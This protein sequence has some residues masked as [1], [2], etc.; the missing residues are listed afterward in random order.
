MSS[1]ARRIPE[2]ELHAYADGLLLV[3]RAFEEPSYPY[4]EALPDPAREAAHLTGELAFADLEVATRRL[5]KLDTTGRRAGL[6]DDPAKPY[7]AA[8]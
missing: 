4:A 2:S 8:R 7:R 5:E 6:K 3:V 1:E